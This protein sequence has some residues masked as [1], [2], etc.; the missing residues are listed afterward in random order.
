MV[1]NLMWFKEEYSEHGLFSKIRVH[2]WVL[3]AK[4]PYY[5]Q[6]PKKGPEFREV[7]IWIQG[8]WSLNPKP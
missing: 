5:I 8:Y 6:D 2:F 1:A 7:P 3:T 4:V